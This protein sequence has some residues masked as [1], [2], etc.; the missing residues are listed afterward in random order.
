[1]SDMKDIKVFARQTI[2]DI[3]IQHYGSIDGVSLLLVDNRN[4]LTDGY[5]TVLHSGM[6]LKVR[7][8]PIDQRTYNEIKTRDIVPAT[9]EFDTP[10]TG[11]DYNNDHNEDHN[12]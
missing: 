2:E 11:P 5:S 3:A 12:V 7:D 10:T 1:M 8:T 9:G 6:I 4:T